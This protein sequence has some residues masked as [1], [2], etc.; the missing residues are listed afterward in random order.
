MKK[1]YLLALTLGAF[2]FTQAQV[3]YQD[4]FDSYNEGP[5]STQNPNW[6]T[7]SGTPAPGEDAFVQSEYSRSPDNSLWID[8][9]GIMDPIFLIPSAP[10]SGMYTVQWYSYIPAGKSGY[11]NM[12][13]KLTA[14]GQD[15]NQ[16]LMGGNV[17]F[18]CFDD[19]TGNGGDM[20]G[21]G[22][23]AGTIDCSA[24]EAVFF[25]P[26]DEWFK[27]TCLYDLDAETWAMY[28]NDTL[29]FQGYP[30]EFGA[31]NFEE[32][33]GL[34]FY[35]ASSNNEMYIDDFTAGVGVLSTENF[36]PEVFSVYPNPVK[37]ILNIS[38]KVA[39]DQVVVYDILGKVV[40]QANPGKISPAI[41]MSSLSSGTYMVKVKIGNNSK[42]VK[43][44]K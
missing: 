16:N 2:T 35:S 22:G 39:V 1:I 37:D 4:N 14:P 42:I 12:Q 17:Y 34:D 20:N 25:Y 10:T 9:S 36:V 32:L 6:R 5:I 38:S 29:Q 19:A 40:L 43:I 3:E 31:Y 44:V 7:W 8:D 24:F 15:W 26:E 33:A 30:F 27:V 41:D 23:V 13:A 21:Q 28:I 18:N 11:F